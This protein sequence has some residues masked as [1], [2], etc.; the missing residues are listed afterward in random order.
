MVKINDLNLKKWKEHSDIITDSLWIIPNRDN[1][2]S[3]KGDYHGNFV[4]Q[5]PYQLISRYTKKDD[6]VLDVFLGSGTTLIEAKRLGRNG[7]GIE[8]VP[9][10]AKTAQSRINQSSLSDKKTFS[11]VLIEDSTSDEARRKVEQILK[12]YNKKQVQLLIMHPPYHDI[13]KFSNLK[14]DLSNASSLDNFLDLFDKV[15]MNFLPLLEKNRF[16]AIV[17]GDKYYQSEWIPLESYILQKTLSH[18]EVLL[19]SVIIKNMVN[20]RAKRNQENLWRYRALTGGFYIF[21]HEY[22]LLFQKR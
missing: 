1:S 16:I 5:I 18:K 15:L 2:S 6:T 8:L 20:N 22:I 14:K 13:I 4:P 21:R 3:H 12:K 19:K 10:V 7:I 9:S 17:I 11:E